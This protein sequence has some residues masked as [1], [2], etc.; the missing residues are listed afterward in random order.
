MVLAV[1]QLDVVM[2]VNSKA[3]KDIDGCVLIKVAD[4]VALQG[5]IRGQQQQQARDASTQSLLDS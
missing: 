5:N 4:L 2:V 1:Q 3:L